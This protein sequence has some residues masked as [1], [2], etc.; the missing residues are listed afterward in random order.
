MEDTNEIR[1]DLRESLP[2]FVILQ[3]HGS[4]HNLSSGDTVGE[5]DLGRLT[6]EGKMEV[7]SVAE[8]EIRNILQR[9]SKKGKNVNFFILNS[10]SALEEPDTGRQFGK[11]AKD[12]GVV[13]AQTVKDIASQ[14]FPQANV[15]II[16]FGRTESG[17]RDTQHLREPNY[18]FVSSALKRGEDPTDYKRAL[19]ESFG[20]N[21]RWEAYHNVPV[22][23]EEIRER[24]GAEG[25]IDISNRVKFLIRALREYSSKYGYSG[26]D[27]VN[28]YWLI[29][30]NDI[31]R[32]VVQHG[33][34]AG[35]SAQGYNPPPGSLLKIELEQE[36]LSLDFKGRTING[37]L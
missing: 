26:P 7:R 8:N 34:G 5:E 15:S 37:K 1:E 16:E 29:T 12:S 3:R 20:E 4:Y 25:P 21:G 24:V 22:E 17:T 6:E 23:L 33:L 28:V 2:D 36:D 10:P 11:R 31:L 19:L 27:S 14:D 30:H 35:E 32:S 9:A 18:H 13:V